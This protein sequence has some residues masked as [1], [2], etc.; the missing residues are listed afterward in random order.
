VIENNK[1]WRAAT[2][3]R[4]NWLKALLAKKTPPKGAL[5]LVF[6]EMVDPRSHLSYSME[7]QHQTACE[8][9]GV[10]QVPPAWQ[11]RD[12]VDYDHSGNLIG[13]TQRGTDARPTVIALAL[14]LGSYESMMDGSVW[15][16]P[17]QPHGKY[18]STLLIWGYEPSDIELS[19]IDSVSKGD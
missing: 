10:E 1:A 5:R 17:S 4:I 8:L 14:V 16:S 9:L 3:V 15:R 13:V 19:V 2:T 12:K 11:W 7:R 18:L 6:A